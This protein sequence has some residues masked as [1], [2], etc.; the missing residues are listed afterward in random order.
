MRHYVDLHLASFDAS[1]LTRVMRI[2][3]SAFSRAP[4][5]HALSLPSY[6]TR[7]PFG[8]LRI[9][10]ES[11]SVQA[12]FADYVYG[13]LRTEKV[14][15]GYPASVP[16][17]FAG[18]FAVYARFRVPARNSLRDAQDLRRVTRMREAE[19]RRL[20]YFRAESHSNGNAFSIFIERLDWTSERQ[21]QDGDKAI[22]RAMTDAYGLSRTTRQVPLPEL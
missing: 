15:I 17:D 11:E 7:N 8:V 21:D 16:A 14:I 10:S 12:T 13:A 18:P 1:R 3:H 2:L 22:E 9:F 6:A 4:G 19:S 5:R 20:P